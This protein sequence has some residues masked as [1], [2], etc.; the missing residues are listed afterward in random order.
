MSIS[1]ITGSEA[2][3]TLTGDAGVMN[4]INGLGGNDTLTGRD[5][6]DSLSGGDGHD[7]LMG[8]AGGDTLD[9]GDGIDTA[10]YAG[11]G[12]GVVVDLG[13]GDTSG[14]DADG[15]ILTDIEGVIGSDASDSIY[16]SD[17]END[18]AGG[19]GDD[20]LDGGGGSD[21]LAGGKGNDT[22]IGGGDVSNDIADF[23]AAEGPVS[24]R[25]TEEADPDNYDAG[26]ATGE[27]TDLLDGF[28]GAFGSAYGDTLRGGSHG[29]LLVGGD[30]D[31]LVS[32][33]DGGDSLQGSAGA[34]TLQGGGGDDELLGGAGDDTLEGGAGADVLNGDD[35]IDTA[36]YAQSG[37]AVNVDLDSGTGTGG[38]A[39]G[40]SYS[41]IEAVIGSSQ[42]DTIYGA[43]GS[44]LLQGGQGNDQVLGADGADTVEG[45]AGDDTLT[46][47]EGNDRLD[48]GDGFDMAAY[49]DHSGA[50][51]VNLEA[52]TSSLNDT[53]VGMEGAHGGDYADTLI[54]S[55]DDNRLIGGGA[56][57]L[58]QGAAGNDDLRGEQGDDTLE[59]GDGIDTLSGG[60]GNDV[61]LGVEGLDTVTELAAGGHDEVQTG[62]SLYTLVDH[63]EDLT[64]TSS[65]GQILIGNAGDN[66]ITGGGGDDQLSGGDSGA[67]TLDGGSGNDTFQA[68]DGI[69]VIGGDG[70]DMLQLDGALPETITALDGGGFT[71]T[72]T[73]DGTQTVQG[74]EKIVDPSG[75]AL[76]LVG[77]GGFASLQDAL[78][79]AQPGDTIRLFEDSS[80]EFYR[81]QFIVRTGGI[82]IE[83]AE[84]HDI[85]LEAPDTAN[86]VQTGTTINGWLKF[87]I[88]E[89]DVADPTQGAV[90]VRG[91]TIDGRGQGAASSDDPMVGIAISDT[92]AVIEDVTITGIREP[93]ESD[94]NLSGYS[95]HYGI[96]AEGSS[97]LETAVTVEVRNSTISD[98]QK[99]GIVAWGPKLDVLIEDNT[100]N[101]S[102]ERGK[103]NQNGMQIGSAASNGRDGTTGIIRNNTIND[104]AP[105]SPGYSAT[106]ILVRQAGT[107]EI[108][109]NTISGPA[110]LS[111]P[112]ETM[113]S[114]GVGLYEA[115]TAAT[116]SNN[117]FNQTT[118]GVF[119][120]APW[121][122]LETY[123]A[124]HVLSG[125]H[126]ENAYIGVYDS[127]DNNNNGF[128]GLAQNALT[129]TVDSSAL[130]TNG[131]GFIQYS[132]FGGDDSFVDTGAAA[133]VLDAGDGA[134]TITAGSG[135]D[136]LDGGAGDDT[137]SGGAGND[138]LVGG[139]GSNLLQGDAGFD[140]ADY[141]GESDSIRV[142]LSESAV[143]RA[144]GDDTLVSIEAVIGTDYSDIMRGDDE[145]NVLAG[146]DGNDFFRAS[147]GADTLIG[148]DGTDWVVYLHEDFADGVVVSLDSTQPGGQSAAG[149]MLSE[150]EGVI[151]TLA[152]D[153]IIGD[154]S[155]AGCPVDNIL[156]GLAGDDILD[157]GYGD[158]TLAGG[159]GDDLLLGGEGFDTALYLARSTAIEV[160]LDLGYV[161]HGL[162][163]DELVAIEGVVGSAFDDLMIGDAEGNAFDGLDG[164][165]TLEGGAGGDSLHGGDG[166]DTASYAHAKSGV[167]ASLDSI[168]ID[169]IGILDA[170]DSPN[171]GEALGDLYDSIENLEGSIYADALYGNAE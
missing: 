149:Q 103:S 146:G 34:D 37:A 39:A 30:G 76:L 61:Y 43:T 154:V 166:I 169:S 68:T 16:G 75:R 8:G 107:L 38:D 170:P 153:W 126:Y 64:G 5:S 9:G 65:D 140:T 165:D 32:G 141:S 84:G 135:A 90:T 130:V 31:D 69:V 117:T 29:D 118:I 167:T 63:V 56:G 131:R 28:E 151:G 1:T 7:L 137:L 139:E 83:A 21:V 133:T 71:I 128:D 106:G 112:I 96:V 62:L 111:A 54:G 19:D 162:N 100:I 110:E 108:S 144:D 14:G 127:Q 59:G 99:T 48:G 86:Q 89:L 93:L 11:S 101:A 74:L 15:D 49:Y 2:D 115:G 136:S 24:V 164:D 23:R 114:V 148:G 40:D 147:L 92:A 134:D 20:Y 105:G 87:S 85:T 81:G 91:I 125:N 161:T 120:E 116:V 79:A 57:D 94:D 88:L 36:D 33:G 157:G 52:G 46:G 41:S 17:L 124:A 143:E 67:D 47:G 42:D 77:N 163:T 145:A 73:S 60:E 72:T 18:L 158:D 55:G 50:V 129:I 109:G 121:G 66:V 132:L 156:L 119:I 3:D 104:I 6:A 168:G 98:F 4:F 150:I 53:L 152:D 58:L 97:A 159:A 95:T 155:D 70:I 13:T 45:G 12:V 138:T 10:S 82:T 171:T 26:G 44:Q 51:M 123:D 113:G 35:G 160:R 27:G 122:P 80:P 22:L 102:G 78:D 25:L 142:D